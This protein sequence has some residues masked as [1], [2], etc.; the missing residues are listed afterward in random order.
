MDLDRLLRVRDVVPVSVG[1]P[2]LSDHLNQHASER[3]VRNMR[4]TRLIGLHVDFKL[5]VLQHRVFFHRL[6]VDAGIFHRFFGVAPRDDDCYAILRRRRLLFLAERGLI[7]SAK[8]RGRRRKCDDQDKSQ[9]LGAAS[10]HGHRL[11]VCSPLGVQ[12]SSQRRI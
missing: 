3:R 8:N 2:S 10:D 6:D 1:L 11:L 4:D 9:D 5:F 12:T 7:L